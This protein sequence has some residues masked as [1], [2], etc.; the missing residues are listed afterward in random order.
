[1]ISNTTSYIPTQL[2]YLNYPRLK[3]EP[4]LS[5]NIMSTGAAFGFDHTST[6]LRGIYE[7][8]ERDAFMTVYLCRIPALRINVALLNDTKIQFIYKTYNRYNLETYL[9]E[10]TNDLKIPSFLTVLVDRNHEPHLT[11]GLKSSF[12]KKEAIIGSMEEA[13]LSRPWQRKMIMDNTFNTNKKPESM[14]TL[15]ERA[16]LWRPY[17]MLKKLNFLLLKKPKNYTLQTQKI[18]D[19]EALEKIKIILS[20]CGYQLIYTDI[21]Y[22]KLKQTGG[23]VYKVFIPDLQPLY[24]KEEYK[25]INLMR[26]K[27]VSNYFGIKKIT[28]NTFPH[29]FL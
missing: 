21:T 29:P 7:I 14:S 19:D 18:N 10:I 6:L 11:L 8:V 22:E 26:L 27:T 24:L 2:V 13:F 12:N 23:V 17:N 25:E 16:V 3:N 4:M 15:F 5:G 20:R 1:M 28:I 9:F